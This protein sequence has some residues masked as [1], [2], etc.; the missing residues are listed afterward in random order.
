MVRNIGLSSSVRRTAVVRAIVRDLMAP[1]K[2]R[3]PPAQ[4][5]TLEQSHARTGELAAGAN[6][7]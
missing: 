3:N 7:A 5:I 2:Q 1:D 6:F 4:S